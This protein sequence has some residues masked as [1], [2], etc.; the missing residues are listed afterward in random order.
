[1]LALLATLAPG[2]LERCAE[3]R[4]AQG[5]EKVALANQ[6]GAANHLTKNQRL[7][8][9]QPGATRSLYRTIDVQRLCRAP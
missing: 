3:W 5:V 9:A 1:M 2:N 7:A 8:E 4:R 6:L